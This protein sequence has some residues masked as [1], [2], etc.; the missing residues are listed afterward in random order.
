MADKKAENVVT[1]AKDESA[2]EREDAVKAKGKEEEVADVDAP[3]QENKPTDVDP[4]ADV[5]SEEVKED[6]NVE[7]E[8]DYDI[9]PISGKKV[10]KDSRFNPA[11]G[12]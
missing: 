6:E 7:E 5:P 9:D 3:A 10:G 2:P 4:E 11:Y 12:L 8:E 1:P